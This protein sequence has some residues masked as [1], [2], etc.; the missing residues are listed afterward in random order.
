LAGGLT[1]VVTLIGNVALWL[2]AIV[3]CFLIAMALTQLYM[4]MAG[5]RPGTPISP[6][7]LAPTPRAALLGLGYGICFVA[8]P[9]FLRSAIRRWWQSRSVRDRP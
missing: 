1:R 2:T 7:D 3:G 6:D 9:F 5:S 4:L 8:A